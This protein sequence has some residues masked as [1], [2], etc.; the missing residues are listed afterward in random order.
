M[1]KDK[2]SYNVVSPI[3]LLYG[4]WIIELDLAFFRSIGI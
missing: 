4:I 2:F 3:Q 1:S